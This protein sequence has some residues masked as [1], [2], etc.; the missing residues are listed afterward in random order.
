[1]KVNVYYQNGRL[2]MFDTQVYCASEPFKRDGVNIVSEFVLLFDDQTLADEGL[3]LETYWYDATIREGMPVSGENSIP[4]AVR[5]AGRRIRLASKGELSDIAK[6]TCDGEL[7]VW[8]QGDDLIN[9]NKFF[10]QEVLC[11]SDAVTT[12]INRRALAIYDYLKRANPDK[13]E[14]EVAQMLGYTKSALDKI[15]FEEDANRTIDEDYDM[16]Q[17]HGESEDADGTEGD[18]PS[19]EVWKFG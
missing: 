17:E 2:D 16:E 1:M 12:S 11:F 10:V 14:N 3:M 15:T 4:H 9:G 6:I 8:R 18:Q 5:Q 13:E 19:D 7:V